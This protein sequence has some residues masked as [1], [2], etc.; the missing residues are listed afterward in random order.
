MVMYFG[1]KIQL[2][3]NERGYMSLG[4]YL[5]DRFQSRYLKVMAACVSVLMTMIFFAM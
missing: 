2:L 3:A 5:E 4:D 1:N